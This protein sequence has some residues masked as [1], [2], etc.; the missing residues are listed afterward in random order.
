MNV[1]QDFVPSQSGIGSCK[2]YVAC[3]TFEEAARG[4][5]NYYLDLLIR[6]ICPKCSGR[7][8][9]LGYTWQVRVRPSNP[10]Y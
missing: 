4:V 10:R 1:K 5:R 3:L 9:E 2:E 7:Q 6:A 8:S